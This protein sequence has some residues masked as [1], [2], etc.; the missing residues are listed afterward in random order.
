MPNTQLYALHDLHRMRSPGSCHGG[1]VCVETNVVGTKIR[2]PVA[3]PAR[4]CV[5]LVPWLLFSPSR[6]CGWAALRGLWLGRVRRGARGV[7]Q[8][9][10][11]SNRLHR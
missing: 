2:G 3:G 4:F 11:T 10:A 6:A 1:G 8:A 5:A 9:P 7:G